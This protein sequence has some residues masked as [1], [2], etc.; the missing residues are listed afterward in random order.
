MLS[1]KAREFA[2]GPNFAVLTTLLPGGHPAGQ[3]MWV[4]CDDETLLLNTEKHRQKF[5][6]IQRDPRVTVTIWKSDDPY[7][8]VEVRGRV[9]ETV[10]GSRARQHIDQLALK[11]F[12]RLYDNSIIESER[13]I[14]RIR[15]LS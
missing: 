15:P 1:K 9:V 10:G 12:G 11:Y 8:Y 3:V 14:L 13:V 6:N 4:D 5:K 2:E 7:E